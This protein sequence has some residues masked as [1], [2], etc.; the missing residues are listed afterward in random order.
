MHVC[1]KPY[2]HPSHSKLS[3]SRLLGA[4]LAV[5]LSV[6]VLLGVGASASAAT[7]EVKMGTDMGML[8]FE[9][10]DLTIS[11]GDTVKFVNNKLGPHNAVFTDHDEL[12]HAGLA[13]AA[14]ESWEESFTDPGTYTYYCEPHRGAGM[15][16]TIT[17]Q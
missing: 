10:K 17:V 2:T 11:A 13:F 9:P 16:G 15:V 4:C 1:P 5:V 14:G 8:A 7:V 6:S 3:M 12:S